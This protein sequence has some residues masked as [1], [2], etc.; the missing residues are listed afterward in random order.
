[1]DIIKTFHDNNF[2]Q[3]ITIIESNRQFLFKAADVA[4]VLDI[5][6]IH[7]S[8]S[9]FDSTEKLLRLIDTPGGT[10][11]V[12]FLTETGLYRLLM[13]S[14]KEIAIQFQRWVCRV[15]QEIRET[16][17]YIHKKQIQEMQKEL[18]N[19]KIQKETLEKQLEEQKEVGP[20]IYIFQTD[21]KYKENNKMTLK[22]GST[23]NT[24]DRD[25]TFKTVL[26][27]GRMAFRIQCVS[28]NLRLTENWIHSLLK[29]FRI[30]GEV[31]EMQ[32]ELAKK[33][34]IHV[35]NMM[36][37]SQNPNIDDM[38]SKL[39]K[40]VDYENKVLNQEYGFCATKEIETQTEDE[41]F[42]IPEEKP[43]NNELNSKF[44]KYIDE[45]CVIDTFHEVSAKDI[46]GQYRLWARSADKETFHAL[47]D[48]LQTKFKHI[49]LPNPNKKNVVY[50]YRGLKLKETTPFTLPFAPT[51]PEN[52]LAH[53]CIFSPS[54]KVIMNDLLEEYE[55]W[56]KSVEKTVDRVDLKNYLKNSPRVLISNVWAA[57]GN[58][59][60]YYGLSLKKEENINRTSSTAKKVT[61]RNE[62]G[63][64]IATWTTIAKAAQDEGFPT[65]KL[66]RAIKNETILNGFR[67]VCL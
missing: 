66:S 46:E 3:Q 63:E 56:G 62:D 9:D 28:D 16:G 30:A 32:Y 52:F 36:Q 1:M 27:D 29:P 33:W 48:Y 39:S 13:R 57:S 45:C 6:N 4:N 26:P 18:E 5:S 37:L 25:K 10:Q 19:V 20:F 41:Y 15:I 54:G 22:I 55:K 38:E 59:Q 8:L 51:N 35:G 40:I 42:V 31:F 65:A 17:E 60:G 49:R 2:S 11:M 7:S 43:I 67:Y 47:K 14:R 24:R 44:D 23:K 34:V 61:K 58:G 50:G 53:A 64:V 21:Q 12:T